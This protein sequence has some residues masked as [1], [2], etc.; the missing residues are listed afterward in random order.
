[1]KSKL[2]NKFSFGLS[3][4]ISV[5]EYNEI[6]NNYGDFIN[7]VYFSLPLGRA[8]HTRIRVVEEY[9]SREAKKKLFEILKLFKENGKKLEVVINQYG[10][11]ESQL[12]EAI[13]YINQ[14][15]K[16]DS[17]CTLDE[18]LPVLYESY[19]NAYL[20][21]SFNNLKLSANDIK[22]TSH[23]YKQIVVGKNFMR[24]IDLLKL[25]K[26][27]KF[28]LKLLLNNGCSFNC[29][30]CR[31]GTKQCADVFNKNVKDIGV[32]NLYAI[33]SFFPSELQRLINEIEV[34]ELKI[35]N[36]PCS[37]EYLNNCLD[38]YINNNENYIN[39]NIKNYHLWGRLGQFTPFYN[40]F[41]F[42]T[43]K[44]I[45]RNLWEKVERDK[46]I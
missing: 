17:I 10:I 26:E 39:D 3:L 9:E 11:T 8:F 21:S 35:S 45:K 44:E 23:K 4:Q 28:D 42:N 32:Q 37:Y 15:I 14:N 22:S 41:D 33:Q 12:L 43:I 34:D 2:Y 38:S 40:E 36:R 20:I 29:G 6:L 1:M 25:I 24:D 30:S 16:F 18:Y 46:V 31:A 19:P 13:K 5:D 7:S 27:E